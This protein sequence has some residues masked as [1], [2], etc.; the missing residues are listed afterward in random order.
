M[1]E[2]LRLYELTSMVRQAIELT[3]TDEY[4]LEAELAEA[5][6]AQNGHFYAEFIEKDSR[7]INII[8]RARATA[9]A[10]TY[11][12]LAPLFER[13]TGERLRSGLKVR[14]R[15]GIAFHEL[16]GFSLNIVDIDPTYTMGDL[17]RRRREI[18]AQL[19][20]DG[21]LEDNRQLE[22]PR[23]LKR[24]AVVSSAGAAGYGDFC[25]Q[26]LANDYGLSFD[27]RLFP[28]VM[29]GVNVE[30]SVLAALGAICDEADRWDCVVIIRGGG[31]TS[32]LSDFDSYAL[33]AA[34]AQMPLPV[35]VGIG[36]ERDETVLDFVAHT[37]V[38]TP[39]AAAALLIDH[40]AQEL[41]A[42]DE[43]QRT[44]VLAAQQRIE[45]SKQQLS[46]LLALLP[47]SFAL[48]RERHSHRLDRLALRLA[49]APRHQLL[50]GSHRL[51]LIVSR[52][53]QASRLKVQGAK[54]KAQ[55]LEAR[56]SA[57]DP[58][59][60]LRRGYSLTYLADGRLL[61]SATELKAGDVITTRLTDGTV[62]SE[63][64]E[65][66]ATQ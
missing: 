34:V 3:F 38:K 59:L 19:E 16:Y 36:H 30:D 48:V 66:S 7:G 12:I 14:V 11:N 10:R 53:A 33:A 28:A 49:S 54:F 2:T 20:A 39:T 21:I 13:A 35:V 37:R 64:V 25:D 52:F 31:A 24:V 4:W 6:V 45:A 61:R 1:E 51:Q 58:A 26:L 8:A 42:I 41:A 46:R 18:L 62:C 17:S 29:Q 60:Q 50:D 57:L 9:W 15:V 23:L 47:R 40:G 65:K 43:L 5:R 56:L 63:V 32:D 22:L 44:I 55:S 27:V